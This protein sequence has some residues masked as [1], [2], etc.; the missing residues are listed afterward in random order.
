MVQG[1]Y[2][3]K[4]NWWIP[5]CIQIFGQHFGNPAI[6][7]SRYSN[8]D[9]FFLPNHKRLNLVLEFFIRLGSQTFR[10]CYLCHDIGMCIKDIQSGILVDI[11][12]R[13]FLSIFISGTD[14]S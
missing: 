8:P 10:F 4:T 9:R 5:N 14:F 6:C 7:L 2:P 3:L 13:T 12:T 1:D 11:L